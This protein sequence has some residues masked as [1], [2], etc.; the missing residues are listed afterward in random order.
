MKREGPHSEQGKSKGPSNVVRLPRDWLGP[1]DELVPF[2]VDRLDD[3]GD[4]AAPPSAA[5]FWG[6]RAG[7]VQDVLQGPTPG[8]R[9]QPAEHESVSAGND[10]LDLEPAPAADSPPLH[11]GP[12]RRSRIVSRPGWS[13]IGAGWRMGLVRADGVSYVRRM[14]SR[15]GQQMGSRTGPMLTQRSR[16][17]RVGGWVG[18]RPIRLLAVCGVSVAAAAAVLALFSGPERHR[19]GGSRP[20][21]TV[22]A[23][24]ADASAPSPSAHPEKSGED[25]REAR[26]V[27][28]RESPDA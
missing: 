6:E 12:K 16:L 27:G 4:S 22:A 2:G 14:G 9:F 15:T 25:G 13:S 23:K 1:R 7:A 3:P 8:Q 10:P 26:R 20:A 28:R 11:S 21:D 24:L 5:D 17:V 18:H 19:P